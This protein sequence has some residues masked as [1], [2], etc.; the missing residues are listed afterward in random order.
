MIFEDAGVTRFD[1]DLKSYEY[2]DLNDK[3]QPWPM[4]TNTNMMNIY[5]KAKLKSKF[6]KRPSSKYAL[7]DYNYVGF[8]LQGADDNP[9]VNCTPKSKSKSAEEIKA[10][11]FLLFDTLLSAEQYCEFMKT[12]T[13]KCLISCTKCISK[14]QPQFICQI[15][16]FEFGNMSI[17]DDNLFTFF[18]LDTS[19]QEYIAQNY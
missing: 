11:G 3:I 9:H 5:S 6:L 14:T 7:E 19:E 18:G 4:F 1:V 10:P 2:Y 16:D 12:K 17:T 15:G 13:Y 8:V